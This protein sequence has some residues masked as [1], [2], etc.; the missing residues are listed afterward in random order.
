MASINEEP[1]PT[2]FAVHC[3]TVSPRPSNRTGKTIATEAPAGTVTFRSSFNGSAP[4]STAVPNGRAS[5]I[6][7]APASSC[8]D[9][10]TSRFS[11]VV[12][13]KM[14]LIRTS[15]PKRAKR[16]T[17]GSTISGLLTVNADEPW[18]NRSAPALTTAINRYRVRLSGTL[19]VL[20]LRPS[21]SVSALAT[22]RGVAT[23][24]FR[25]C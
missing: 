16:G 1:A 9:N 25:V 22:Q 4:T 8:K 15:S 6:K 3:Q 10:S 7:E 14:P 20:K 23:K 13:C 21:A 17:T 18:P 24:F 12:L 5:T 19:T 2:L 11:C